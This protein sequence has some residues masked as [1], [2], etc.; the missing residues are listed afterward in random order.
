MSVFIGI[1]Y[2]D[3]NNIRYLNLDHISSITVVD[4]AKRYE[5]EDKDYGHSTVLAFAVIIALSE[6]GEVVHLLV[7]N[8]DSMG[9]QSLLTA[10]GHSKAFVLLNELETTGE[11]EE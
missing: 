6:T 3:E 10:Q 2:A 5:I 8:S 7:N 4:T 11:D 9:L 1:K